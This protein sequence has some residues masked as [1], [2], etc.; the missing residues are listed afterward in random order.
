VSSV[1]RYL[2]HFTLVSFV[3]LGHY[4]FNLFSS[5]AVVSLLLFRH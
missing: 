5:V 3:C 1:Y 4:I 2:I